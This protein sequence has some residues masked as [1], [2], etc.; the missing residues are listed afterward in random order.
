[1]LVAIIAALSILGA[2]AGSVAR[3]SRQ[4]VGFAGA[5][6]GGFGLLLTLVSLLL[7]QEP[8]SLELPIGLPGLPLRLALD[9]LSAFFLVPVFLSGTAGIA[10]A[11]EV[12]GD[13]PQASLAGLAL[14]LAGV[15]LATLAADG[16]TLV[17]GLSLAGGAIWAS[18]EPGRPRALQLGVTG[19]AAVAM[20]AATALSGP[21]FAAM[22]DQPFHTNAIY[23]LALIGPGAM[24][25]L[26]PLHT[27]LVPAHRAAP[28][29]AAAL[30][31]GAMQPLAL[32]LL[33]RLLLDLSEPAPPLWWGIPLLAMGVAGALTGGWRAATG[34]E[35]GSCFAGLTERQSGL[36]AIGI[37]LALIGRA[38]DLPNLTTS[39]VGAVLLLTVSQAVCG[40][41]AQLAAGAIRTGA[42]SRR[43]VL[44]GGLIHPMPVASAGVA[45]AL[46]GF[47]ALPCGAGFAALWL[48]F[49]ALLAA[50]HSVWLAV[51]AAAL[52]ISAGLSGVALVRVFGVACLGRPR[53]P[54]AAGAQD[55]PKAARPG[56]LALVGVAALI[57]VFPGPLLLLADPAIR[58]LAGAA[59]ID[60]QGYQPLPLLLLGVAVGGAV[61]WLLRRRAGDPPRVVSN[62]QDGFAPSP[63]WLPFGDPVTQSAGAGFVPPLPKLPR[64]PRRWRRRIAALLRSRAA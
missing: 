15:V 29:R 64:L 27:W 36:A 52:A 40:T 57:G 37:G 34:D 46:Y 55:L 43:L 25:G 33:L 30:L 39:A 21:T 12:R 2:V 20:L 47:A 63:S 32:Y 4:A 8:D 35:V 58:Q 45:A 60:A 16:V 3:G 59:L 10:F 54:R 22:R 42:G 51:V 53:G 23:A 9:P 38:S 26:P 56:L 41:L 13:A 5:G 18:G 6:L 48:L 62:W 31:S 44:L 24:A 14:C 1:M 19:A 17:L 11:A 49:Q 7:G 50:P 28:A 61:L